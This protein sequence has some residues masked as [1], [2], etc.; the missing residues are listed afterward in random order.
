MCKEN[1]ISRHSTLLENHI[2]RYEILNT[3]YNL[4]M[5]SGELEWYRLAE[6]IRGGTIKFANLSPCACR[7]STG[8]KP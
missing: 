7:G 6:K 4:S 3:V 2:L 5:N 8:Q 1:L